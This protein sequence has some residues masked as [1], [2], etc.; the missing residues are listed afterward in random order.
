[1]V[2]VGGALMS[3]AANIIAHKPNPRQLKQ[4]KQPVKIR[5]MES[6]KAIAKGGA[7]TFDDPP[8]FPDEI[9]TKT[10]KAIKRYETFFSYEKGMDDFE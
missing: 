3:T 8:Q 9:E 6:R 4:T 5:V 7:N 2:A 1:M 10:I